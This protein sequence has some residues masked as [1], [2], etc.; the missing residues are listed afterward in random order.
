MGHTVNNSTEFFIKPIYAADAW[1]QRAE[2]AAG[3]W[4]DVHDKLPE[5][6]KNDFILCCFRNGYVDACTRGYLQEN[7]HI[8]AW[9]PL[10]EPYKGGK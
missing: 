1:N 9:M 10:P 4:V 6:G 3:Q 8:V 7:D 2:T 5:K